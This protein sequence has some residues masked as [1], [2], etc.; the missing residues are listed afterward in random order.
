MLTPPAP[1]SYTDEYLYPEQYTYMREL[2]RGLDA[3]GHGCLEM[4]TGTGKT[5]TLLRHALPQT[6]HQG[7]LL[8]AKVIV[9]RAARRRWCGARVSP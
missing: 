3:K 8:F 5:I 4:P 2:K 1:S 9:F 6:T 7:G